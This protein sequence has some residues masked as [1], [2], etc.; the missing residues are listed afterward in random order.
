MEGK[1]ICEIMLKGLCL[2]CTGL[3]ERDWIGK[4]QCEF[5]KKKRSDIYASKKG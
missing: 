4:Y 3:V 2:G 5:Y 1:Y